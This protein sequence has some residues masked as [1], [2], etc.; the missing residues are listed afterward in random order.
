MANCIFIKSKRTHAL[1]RHRHSNR[2]VR[3]LLPN[4]QTVER[5]RLANQ[6]FIFILF[7]FLERILKFNTQTYPFLPLLKTPTTH[8]RY[9]HSSDM[10]EINNNK[11]VFFS[12]CDRQIY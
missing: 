8:Q 3:K 9:E 7:Y 1:G 10:L 12:L 4:N 11:K 6:V 5:L 2:L